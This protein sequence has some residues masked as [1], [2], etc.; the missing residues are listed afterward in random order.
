M[1][2]STGKDNSQLGVSVR[3]AGSRLRVTA[4]LINVEDGFHLWS[5]RYDR[6]MAD[7]F[8]IQDEITAAIV[9][10]LKVTLN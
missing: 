7:I 9:D 1:A 2:Y 6:E 10:S 3:K 8:A 4:Q 5:E